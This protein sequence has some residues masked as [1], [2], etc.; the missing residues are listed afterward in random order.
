MS[1]Q[2]DS[3]YENLE[4]VDVTIASGASNS[5]VATS[6]GRALVGLRMPA[7]WDAADLRFKAALKS[8]DTLL[9][10]F[11]SF[12]NPLKAT[13]TES[14]FITLPL[15]QACYAPYVCVSSVDTSGNAVNQTADRTIVLLFRRFLS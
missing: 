15:S 11:D 1:F 5:N 9:P 2:L 12:G 3:R 10:V 13:V 14:T 4:A 8:G 7:G 6:E